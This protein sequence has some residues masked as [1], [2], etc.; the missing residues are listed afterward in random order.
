MPA[1]MMLF[2]LNDK[3]WLLNYLW[4]RESIRILRGDAVGGGGCW[5]YNMI[6][7]TAK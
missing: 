7:L 4:Q 5:R 1:G 6:N 3:K 2:I